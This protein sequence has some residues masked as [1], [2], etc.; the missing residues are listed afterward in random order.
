MTD[1]S[2]TAINNSNKRLSKTLE[3]IFRS[4]GKINKKFYGFQ[5]PIVRKFRLTISQYFILEHLDKYGK[6]QA[7]ELAEAFYSSRST[8]TAV[9]DTMEKNELVTRELNPKDRRSLFVKLTKKGQKLYNSIPSN[10]KLIIDCINSFKAEEIDTLSK[11]TKKL[12]NIL[13]SL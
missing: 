13:D 5:R 1:N 2:N 7:K 4:M 6:I 9:V 3:D 12:L 10:E 8:I 11:L